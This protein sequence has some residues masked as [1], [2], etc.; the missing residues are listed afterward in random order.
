MVPL[1]VIAAILTAVLLMFGKRLLPILGAT[2]ASQPYAW[3]YLKITSLGTIFTVF[4]MG[5]NSFINTQG[6]TGVGMFSVIIG[7]VLNIIFDPV[8]IFGFHMGVKGAATATVISQAISC[9][10]VVGYLCSPKSSLRI[11]VKNLVPDMKILKGVIVLGIAPFLLTGLES[12]VTIILNMVLKRYGALALTGYSTDGATLAITISSIVTMTSSL[13]TMPIT[14]FTQGIQPIISYNYGAGKQDRVKK[15]I[16]FSVIICTAFIAVMCAVFLCTPQ[17]LAGMF[18][19]DMDVIAISAPLIRIF[20]SGMAVLG[21]QYTLQVSFVARGIAPYSILIALIRKAVYIPLLFIL[22][23]LSGASG[24][25]TAI[26]VASP[27]SDVVAA[28][29]T[30]AIFF[31]TYK[32]YAAQ[33]ILS[34]D[35]RVQKTA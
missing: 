3:E 4:V 31:A 14:G 32:K 29:V 10:W 12:V 6:K 35:N 25:I 19:G 33:E 27:I 5:L 18:S 24:G 28:L 8:L 21:I 16:Q 20:I 15:T 2:G 13:I 22:P 34:L 9:L 11:K 26:F 17:V 23:I 30:V 7:A 1:V